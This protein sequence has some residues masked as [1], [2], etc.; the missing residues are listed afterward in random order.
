MGKADAKND[1]RLRVSVDELRATIKAIQ[2]EQAKK[3]R[4]ARYS[5]TS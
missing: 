1:G 5:E 4:V 2:D 3:H